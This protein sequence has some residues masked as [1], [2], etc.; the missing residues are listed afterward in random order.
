MRTRS[1]DDCAAAW[2]GLHGQS[3]TLV[4][5]GG[6]IV[7][8]DFVSRSEVFADLYRKLLGGVGDTEVFLVPR[9]EGSGIPR[10]TCEYSV[11]TASDRGRSRSVRERGENLS[12]EPG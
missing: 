5:V 2:P 1:L 11:T 6:E 10:T 4:A 12:I 8:L 3:G 9:L 7:C